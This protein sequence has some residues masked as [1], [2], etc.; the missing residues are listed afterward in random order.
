MQ[1]PSYAAPQYLW[2]KTK[3]GHSKETK[4]MGRENEDKTWLGMIDF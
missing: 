2:K 3:V 4:T 1:S